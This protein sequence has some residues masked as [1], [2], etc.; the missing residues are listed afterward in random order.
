[1][2]E[3]YWE[4]VAD[5]YED[6]I[7]NVFSHDQHKVIRSTIREFMPAKA[8]VGD[9]GCGIGNG[10]PLLA[11]RARDVYAIDLSPKNL[12]RASS[13]HKHLANVRYV[14][15]DLAKQTP[16]VPR[17]NFAIS[18]NCLISPDQKIRQA[19]LRNI[20]GAMRTG[21]VVVIVVPSIESCLWTYQRTHQAELK[22]RKGS[23]QALRNVQTLVRQEIVSLPEGLMSMD[24]DKT[25]FYL[26]TELDVWLA[27]NRFAVLRRSKLEY[28]WNA[29]F[30]VAPKWLAAPYP[31][32]WLVVARKTN[33]NRNQSN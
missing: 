21:A 11:E 10:I 12:G 4:D 29:E 3:Q 26:G 2:D 8:I 27:E 14:H 5:D 33:G 1:M 6:T 9:M 23:A 17:L 15:C 32:H 7:L 30:H 22:K 16:E 25:K 18:V 31:W 24:G 19:I 13:R 28:G 20:G